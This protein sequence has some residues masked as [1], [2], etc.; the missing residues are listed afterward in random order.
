MTKRLGIFGFP[1]GHSLSPAMHGAAL[2]LLGIDATFEAW[3]TPPDQLRT[4]LKVMRQADHLGASVTLPH[5]QAV[6]PMMDTID[7]WAREIGAVNCIANRGGKLFGF[8][9]D[10]GGFIRA[11]REEAAFDPAGSSVVLLGAG[12]AAR[13]AGFALRRAGAQRLTVA[14]RTMERAEALAGDLRQGRFR[15]GAC[16]I[17]RDSLADVVPYA[18]LIVNATSIGM[19]GGPAASESP[20]S[21]DLI[22]DRALAYDIVYAP[23]VTPFLREAERAGAR[24]VGGLSMLVYQGVEAFKLWTGN[25]PPVDAMFEAARGAIKGSH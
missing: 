12:G 17:D 18:D 21:A 24:A 16:G 23:P 9:T 19:R 7:E 15:P 14:N 10:A 5:K 1:L 3:P 22:S 25:D 13:A 6:I 20:V 4:A 8:N 11:L 2:R